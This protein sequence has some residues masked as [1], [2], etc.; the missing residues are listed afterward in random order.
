[1]ELLVEVQA[2]VTRD[3]HVKNSMD[4]PSE[5]SLARRWVRK[6]DC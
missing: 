5:K 1:M 6:E 3:P 4:Q 2:G